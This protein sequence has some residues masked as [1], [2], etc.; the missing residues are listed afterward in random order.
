MKPHTTASLQDISDLLGEFRAQIEWDRRLPPN[1]QARSAFHNKAARLAM[2]GIAA[3]A[4][5]P[6]VLVEFADQKSKKRVIS[7]WV[8]RPKG[9]NETLSVM[10]L[11]GTQELNEVLRQ[12]AI[13]INEGESKCFV[14]RKSSKVP[15]EKAEEIH[16]QE[17]RT[18]GP[19]IKEAAAIFDQLWLTRMTPS[20]PR[21]KGRR[22]L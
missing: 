4:N 6:L 20:V 12:R 9:L 2:A 13:S 1:T 22:T 5:L 18:G 16:A 11:S 3:R 14:E 10:G 8:V 21:P 17:V 15:P 19:K 7:E